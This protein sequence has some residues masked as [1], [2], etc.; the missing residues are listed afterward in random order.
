MRE[1]TMLTETKKLLEEYKEI[2]P[3]IRAKRYDESY[4]HMREIQSDSNR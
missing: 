4:Q 1:R 3:D 2:P